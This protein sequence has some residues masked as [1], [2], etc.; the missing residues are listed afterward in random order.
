MIE[1]SQTCFTGLAN[2]RIVISLCSTSVK[3]SR[4]ISA[5]LTRVS[6]DEYPINSF[7]F[8]SLA[9]I[10]Q[11]NEKERERDGRSLDI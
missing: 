2:D 1:E 11:Q 7:L 5:Y 6:I 8:L 10:G 9:F 4:I 3:I